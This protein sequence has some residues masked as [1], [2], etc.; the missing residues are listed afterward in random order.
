VLSSP[1]GRP[2]ARK[3]TGQNFDY[4]LTVCD[5]AK[6]SRPVFFGKA[7]RCVTAST[8]PPLWKDPRKGG[9]VLFARSVMRW[10]AHLKIL[11][12]CPRPLGMAGGVCGFTVDEGSVVKRLTEH[13]EQPRTQ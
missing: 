2:A 13:G 5:S 6:E 12:A 7:R 11:V 9:S 3:V 1:E 4:V 10:V 8:I